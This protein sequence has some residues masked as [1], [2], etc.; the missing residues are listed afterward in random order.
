MLKVELREAAEEY[1]RE[2]AADLR[3]IERA[4]VAGHPLDLKQHSLLSCI[5]SSLELVRHLAE[6]AEVYESQMKR[7]GFGEN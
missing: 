5:L 2:I 3:R 4:A 6:Q 1:S 7:R